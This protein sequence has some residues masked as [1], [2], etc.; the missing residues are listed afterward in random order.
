MGHRRE[1]EQSYARHARASAWRNIPWVLHTFVR[2][3]EPHRS[4]LPARHRLRSQW[5]Q[6]I[7]LN[8]ISSLHIPKFKTFLQQLF[9]MAVSLALMMVLQF[10]IHPHIRAQ[11]SHRTVNLR[12]RVIDARTGEPIAKVKIIVG[13]EHQTVTDDRGEW[14]LSGLVPG[15]VEL[16]VTTVGYGLVRKTMLLKEGEDAELDIVLSQE[17]ATL[18]EHVT[19]TARPFEE[20]ETN[21]PSEHTLNKTEIQTLVSVLVSD[22]LRAAQALPGVGAN[23]DFR[24]E[25]AVRG[26]GYRQVG[27]LIDGVLTDNF[28]HSVQGVSDTGSLSVLNADTISAVS[29]LPGAFPVKYGE[30]TAAVLNLETREGNRVKP[31]GRIAVSMVGASAVADGPFAQGRG[32]W[33]GAVRKSYLNDALQRYYFDED[34]LYVFDLVDAQAKAVYDLSARHQASIGVIFG[35]SQLD[36]SCQGSRHRGVKRLMTSWSA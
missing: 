27:V 18:T 9:R 5:V 32:S 23:D 14:T 30:R 16:Y 15:E 12:G 4:V 31:A 33:L 20:T 19:V 1:G 26:A 13:P 35:S 21:A 10:A 28:V 3:G 6:L 34:D 8:L 24:S 2:F 25:F 29:L 11:A 36:R 17:A 7:L 22:P